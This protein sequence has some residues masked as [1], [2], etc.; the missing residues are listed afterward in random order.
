MVDTMGISSRLE[1]PAAQTAV[2]EG[3]AGKPTVSNGLPVPEVRPGTVLVKTETVALM[4]ADYKMGV[5]FP[6]PG[7]IIGTDFVGQVVETGSGGSNRFKI[8]DIVCGAVPGSNPDSPWNGAFAEYV[9]AP[10]DLLCHVPSHISRL[11]AVS[12][13]TPLLTCT[14]ALWGSLGLEG[15]PLNPVAP[16]HAKDVLVYGGSSTCGTMAIQLLKL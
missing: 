6:T 4:P 3:D 15:T 14:V 10:V 5:A 1:I 16:A 9:L 13:G 11:D 7:A 2:V 8:G 12:T